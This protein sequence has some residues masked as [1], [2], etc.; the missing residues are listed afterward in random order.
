[1]IR[2]SA[3]T[4]FILLNLIFLI[5]AARI[6]SV[7]AVVR[8]ETDWSKNK[9]NPLYIPF[10]KDPNKQFTFCVQNIQQNYMKYL[11]QPV[12]YM[13]GTMGETANELNTNLLDI[14]DMTYYMRSQ[15]AFIVKSIFS[16]LT[17]IIIEFQRTTVK[18]QSLVSRVNALTQVTGNV[19]NGGVQTLQSL[20]KEEI[21]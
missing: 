20:E 3:W 7:S 14:R 11:L 2:G 5:L 15:I 9:C 16:V 6:I 1:M 10:A 19:V 13:I 4:I 12:N 21:E 18:I 17:A 8:S